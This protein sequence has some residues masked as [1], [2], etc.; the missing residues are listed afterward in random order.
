MS[1]QKTAHGFLIGSS[2]LL[3]ILLFE[4]NSTYTLQM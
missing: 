4:K 3:D 2:D 1:N